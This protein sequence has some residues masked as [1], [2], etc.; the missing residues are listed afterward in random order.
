M[1]F[2]YII[3]VFFVFVYKYS[4][5]VY[6]VKVCLFKLL[7]FWGGGVINKLFLILEELYIDKLKIFDYMIL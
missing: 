4:N 1:F 6:L 2:F 7:F 3:L 5:C